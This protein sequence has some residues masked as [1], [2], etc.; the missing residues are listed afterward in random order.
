VRST[1]KKE[2]GGEREEGALPELLIELHRVD[3]LRLGGEAD[4]N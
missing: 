3:D 2:P 4:K 1:R